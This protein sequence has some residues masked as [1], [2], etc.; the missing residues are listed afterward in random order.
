MSKEKLLSKHY[1]ITR[2][3][4]VDPKVWERAQEK[5]RLNKVAISRVVEKM[6]VG[7][8]EENESKNKQ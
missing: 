7:W 5:A 4:S 2:T 3:V 1:R 8:L 6:L